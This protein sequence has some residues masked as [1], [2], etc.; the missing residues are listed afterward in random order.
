LKSTETPPTGNRR[1]IS[2]VA[3][4]WSAF[5]LAGYFYNIPLFR[6]I[7]GSYSDFGD[8]FFP[9][10]TCFGDG[11]V[12][13][14]VLFF[15]WPCSAVHAILGLESLVISGIFVRI[16]KYTVALPRPPAVLDQVHLVGME[17]FKNSFPSGH[18]A[19]AF[20]VGFLFYS[21]YTRRAWKILALVIAVLVGYSR[22]YL[23][24][25]FPLDAV[26]G[27][28]IGLLCSKLILYQERPLQE[29][30]ATLSG[31]RYEILHRIMMGILVGG[32]LFLLFL[33]NQLPPTTVWFGDLLGIATLLV[34]LFFL[35]RTLKSA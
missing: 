30:F 12:L 3:S 17:Y 29:W 22:I 11:L 35:F 4:I 24:I 14:I 2:A 20:A 27:A 25:H 1:V 28:G 10:I 33:Y 31:K 15:L 21:Y 34:G 26:G 18:T 7:N 13:G 6:L 9:L 5:F 8:R 16:L 32:G 19:S 23:G